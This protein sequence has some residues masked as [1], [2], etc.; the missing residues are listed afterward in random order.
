MTFTT[1]YIPIKRVNEKKKENNILALRK[2][3]CYLQEEN[4]LLLQ[5]Q[6]ICTKA[7]A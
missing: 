3:V 4:Q 6:Q 5:A 7:K 1:P 2:K